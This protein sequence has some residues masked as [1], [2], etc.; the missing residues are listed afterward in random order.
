MKVR[1]DFAKAGWSLERDLGRRLRYADA[2]SLHEAMS[3]D[4]TT[5][6]GAAAL[7]LAFPMNATDITILHAI[8]ANGLVDARDG[9]ENPDDPAPAEPHDTEAHES[10]L[11]SM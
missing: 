6:T 1:A 4:P 5:Y 7:G 9:S 3:V 10:A 2:I 11:F 8:G